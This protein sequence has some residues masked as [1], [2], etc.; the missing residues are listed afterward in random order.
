MEPKQI[1]TH[2]K[3]ER[4]EEKPRKGEAADGSSSDGK[5][6]VKICPACGAENAP[7]MK[8][9]GN[10]GS[11]LP[12][13]NHVE[14][15]E[16]IAKSVDSQPKVSAKAKKPKTGL[17]VGVVIAAVA[18][19]A[20]VAVALS[21]TVFSPLAKADKLY[22]SGSYA[23]ALEIYKTVDESDDVNAKIRNCRYNLFIDYLAEHG[24]YKTSD[25]D[26]TWIVEGYS[27][28]DIKCSVQSQVSGSAAVGSDSSWVMT[29]HKDSTTADLS[30]S[31]KIKILSQSINE[32]ASGKIDLPS[33]TYGKNITMDSYS[34]SG[35]TAGTSLVKSNSGVVKK[36]I[37][38]GI[39]GAISW[40]PVQELTLSDIGFTS[41]N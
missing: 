25:S 23:E 37:Q 40:C 17:I 30:A 14:K 21:Q 20:I 22:E 29:I 41:L 4:M 33:Y 38:K 12:E 26:V 11:K 3:G 24:P 27:N 31:E 13:Q 15:A 36:M 9:C 16:Q 35:T 34:N 39:L 10:C 8:F 18:V 1:G 28:G 5:T 32:T 6:E 2:G 7:S 19:V